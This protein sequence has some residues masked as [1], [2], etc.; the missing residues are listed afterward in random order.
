M[1]DITKKYLE[2]HDHGVKCPK[3]RSEDILI[4]ADEHGHFWVI[5]CYGCWFKG[6]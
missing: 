2:V 5:E 6:N 3:C 4:G 1:Q